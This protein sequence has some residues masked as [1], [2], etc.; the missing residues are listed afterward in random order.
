M[1]SEINYL[2]ISEICSYLGIETKLSW[3]MDYELCEEDGTIGKAGS[4]CRRVTICPG[5]AAKR[6]Y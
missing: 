6:L 5:Y 2:F 1:L 4:G 3:S